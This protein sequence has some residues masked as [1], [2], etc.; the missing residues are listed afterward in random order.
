MKEAGS[1]YRLLLVAAWKW[2]VCVCVCGCFPFTMILQ[3]KEMEKRWDRKGA[4]AGSDGDKHCWELSPTS[5]QKFRVWAAG[6]SLGFLFVWRGSWQ[7]GHSSCVC[8]VWNQWTVD[9]VCGD[10]VGHTIYLFLEIGSR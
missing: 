2:A 6:L 10:S 5:L 7:E 4:L 8:Y 3:N 1:Y 9:G